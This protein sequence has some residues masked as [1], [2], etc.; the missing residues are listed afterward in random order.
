MALFYYII[1][2]TI[3]NRL[4]ENKLQGS[5]PEAQISLLSLAEAFK[6]HTAKHYAN[7][8]P[9]IKNNT[10]LKASKLNIATTHMAKLPAQF[11]H[12]LKSV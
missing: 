1:N 9:R 3:P 8:W 2:I 11:H 4:H 6:P 10:D 7:V 12:W 5:R